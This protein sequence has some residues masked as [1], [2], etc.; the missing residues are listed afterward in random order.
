ML[1]NICYLGDM[2]KTCKKLLNSNSQRKFTKKY[3]ERAQQCGA[4][5]TSRIRFYWN[6]FKEGSLN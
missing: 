4:T 2:L 3:Q 5:T 1:K 6:E